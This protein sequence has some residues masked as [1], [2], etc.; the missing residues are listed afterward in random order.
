MQI[1]LILIFLLMSA[2]APYQAGQ[3][4]YSSNLLSVPDC[5]APPLVLDL[6]DKLESGTERQWSA[7]C[8]K[9]AKRAK[10]PATLA[11]SARA[12]A[13]KTRNAPATDS[14]ELGRISSRS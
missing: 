7:S 14:P 4:N 5:Y 2:A 6:K 8:C 11:S 12:L 9:F 1:C 10:R 13:I 3:F